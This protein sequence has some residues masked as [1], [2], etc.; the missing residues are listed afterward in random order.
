MNLN[1][2]N[3]EGENSGFTG[4]ANILLIKTNIMLFD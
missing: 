4:S 1:G 3:N 2:K